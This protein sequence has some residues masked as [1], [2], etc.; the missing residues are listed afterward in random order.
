[1]RFAA[2]GWISF[3]RSHTSASPALILFFFSVV[4]T[5]LAQSPRE[6]PLSAEAAY[7]P[8]PSPNGKLIAYVRTGWGR[9]GGSGGMGRSNLVS[10]VMI[11]ADDGTPITASPL[12]DTFLA[13]WTADG[14]ELICYRDWKYSLVALSGKA[15]LQGALQGPDESPKN[16]TSSVAAFSA[17]WRTE[18]VFYLSNLRT[19]GWSRADQDLNAETESNTVIETQSTRIAQH[20]GW[21]GEDVVPSPD[22]RYLAVFDDE[23]Q[24]DLWIYDMQSMSWF[25]LGPLTIHPDREWGYMKA[26]WDPWFSDSSKLAYL[27][28]SRLI[29]SKPDGTARRSFRIDRE[30]G[31]PTPSPDGKSVAYVTFDPRP[32]K[33]RADLS[34]WGGT[35]LW[36]LPLEAGA[37]P[38]EATEKNSDTTYDL[39]WLG[40]GAI[41]FDRFGDEAFPEHARIW[42]VSIG[43]DTKNSVTK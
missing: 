36:I 4:S 6:I 26:T 30:A 32:M 8:I 20:S 17:V 25:D 21:L 24:K 18:R 2:H 40:N 3:N 38:I 23:W 15:S 33:S 13:G 14:N 27:S 35:N 5:A 43:V 31:L 16:S 34:F 28:G 29:V 10:E 42:K 7:N 41:V 37:K 22:G 11:I 9:P 12:T 1:M 19:F 39:R